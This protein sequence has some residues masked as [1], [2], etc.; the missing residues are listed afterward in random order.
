MRE[1]CAAPVA[2]IQTRG[3][4][5]DYGNGKGI[6]DLDLDVDSGRVHGFLGP[7]GAGKTTTIRMLLDFLRPTRGSA[8]V[9][10]KD[11]RE[12]AADIR[13][14]VGYVPGDLALPGHV[15]GEQF[16][17]DSADIR[18]NVDPDWQQHLIERLGAE[19]HRKIRTLSKGN[20][21]KLALIDAFQH[22]P[23]V[24]VM[25][26][27]TDGLDPV[28]RHEVHNLVRHHAAHGGTV[29]LSSH[30][31]HEIQTG[32]DDVSIILAGRLRRRARIHD[33]LAQEPTRIEATMQTT[34]AARE[35][36]MQ[37]PGIQHLRRRGNRIA[38]ELRGEL[39]PA[40]QALI[41]LQA[42]DVM[43]SHD[44]EETFLRLYS[45]VTA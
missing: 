32:C 9:L 38:F 17:S 22:Q 34:P 1:R 40:M 6:F 18:G 24:L 26:E 19:V 10:G 39:L 15:T 36:L 29:F 41:D 43:V 42:V 35:R 3:L 30:V 20:K 2:V 7:N 37:V 31:V 44:L 28:L 16:L 8:L 23:P 5:K 14:E 25:D 45:E 21:Q 12:S 13:A 33:L 27:P 11:P 4:T